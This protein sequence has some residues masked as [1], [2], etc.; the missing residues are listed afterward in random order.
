MG[1]VAEKGEEMESREMAFDRQVEETLR[2]Y[3]CRDWST[4]QICGRQLKGT[5]VGG[6]NRAEAPGQ[7]GMCGTGMEEQG[8]ACLQA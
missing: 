8:G 4:A 7:W 3:K 2:G 6:G 1:L 5:L